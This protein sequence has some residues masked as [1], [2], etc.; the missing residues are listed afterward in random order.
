MNELADKISPN[1]NFYNMIVPT[2]IG[3]TLPDNYIETINSSNQEKSINYMISGFNANVKTVPVFDTL[4]TH[5]KEYIY[6]N[7]DHH[8]TALGA[9]YAYED[10]CKKSE[11]TPCPLTKFSQVQYDGFLG[12]FYND[13]GKISAL[14]SNPDTIIAYVPNENAK[15]VYTDKKGKM[16]II[17]LKGEEVKTINSEIMTKYY[18]VVYNEYDEFIYEYT[19]YKDILSVFIVVTYA[20][21]SEYGKIEYYTY[22]I[23]VKENKVLTNKELYEYLNI[24]YNEVKEII[25]SKHKDFYNKD[26]L[27]EIIDYGEYLETINYKEE[28]DKVVIKDKTLYKYNTINP[29]QSLTTY[30]GNINEI[31]LIEL[32]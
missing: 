5:R 19:T 8:W 9:Y 22:N 20:N 18:S 24:D 6:F 1:A 4:M 7:T 15:M 30:P 21:D 32:K 28:N 12:S 25:D 26:E 14:K 11:K 2:S 3:I 17:N 31:K 13:T 16:P 27:K 10:F 29:T 23:N